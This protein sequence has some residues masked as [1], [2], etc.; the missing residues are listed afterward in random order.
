MCWKWLWL[1]SNIVCVEDLVRLRFSALELSRCGKINHTKNG[2]NHGHIAMFTPGR[3]NEKCNHTFADNAVLDL[4]DEVQ[5]A[6]Q[7]QAGGTFVYSGP[8]IF[9][10]T[11]VVV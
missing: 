3:V 10:P 2:A 11:E 5:K 8:F 6:N 7:R 1:K 4:S 9:S